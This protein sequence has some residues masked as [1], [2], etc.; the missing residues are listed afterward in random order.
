MRLDY[1]VKFGEQLLSFHQNDSYWTEWSHIEDWL[2]DA[3]KNAPPSAISTWTGLVQASIDRDSQLDAKTPAT[4][5]N[6]QHYL[7]YLSALPGEDMAQLMASL[8]F[9]NFMEV[10]GGTKTTPPC[11]TFVG[12]LQSGWEPAPL[13]SNMLFALPRTLAIQEEKRG[14]AEHMES[15]TMGT[16]VKAVQSLIMHKGWMQKAWLP[17]PHPVYNVMY[18][19]FVVS[20]VGDM[21]K[22][23][24]FLRNLSK[25]ALHGAPD[26]L[27]WASRQE[28]LLPAHLEAL[29]P[30]HLERGRA[31]EMLDNALGLVL[32]EPPGLRG[33][34]LAI[35]GKHHP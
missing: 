28:Y 13:L 35:M 22:E 7:D 31:R 25:V 14:Y 5:A 24:Q 33:Q 32:N 19:T 18:D 30:L 11:D 1:Y 12:L 9:K 23:A 34:T 6:L 15:S 29:F 21:E 27:A 16:L 10:L 4:I 26:A 2:A 20:D 3:P 8:E 17:K